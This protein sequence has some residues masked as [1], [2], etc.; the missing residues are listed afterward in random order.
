MAKKTTPTPTGT[1]VSRSGTKFSCS[2]KVAAKNHDDGQGFK[3]RTTLER[4]N[5]D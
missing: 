3:W 5:H 2:W 4:V 1:A